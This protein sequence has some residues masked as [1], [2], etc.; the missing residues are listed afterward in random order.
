MLGG[1]TLFRGGLRAGF[2]R[3]FPNQKW[4][5][6]L[7]KVRKGEKMINKFIHKIF[8]QYSMYTNFKHREMRYADTH[9]TMELDLY[10]PEIS[11]AFEHQGYHHYQECWYSTRFDTQRTDREKKEAC[12]KL[13]ITLIE[14][15]YWWDCT[16][17][18]LLATI[19]KFRPDLIPQAHGAPIP[20]NPPDLKPPSGHLICLLVT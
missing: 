9:K 7:D 19:H 5:D 12:A 15:P 8:P 2:Q 4:S 10:L 17:D 1:S 20:E 11:L 18:S 6:G 3:L 16:K 13:G 14:I